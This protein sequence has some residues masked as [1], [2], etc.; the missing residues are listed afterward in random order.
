[1]AGTITH[2]KIGQEVYSKIQI[3]L[4]YNTFI[5]ACQGHDIMYFIKLKNLKNFLYIKK[6]TKKIQKTKIN[7]FIKLYEKKIIENEN[8]IYLKSFLYGYITHHI[9]DSI[10]HPYIIYKCGLTTKHSW[11]ENYIDYSFDDK[12]TYKN[13]PKLKKNSLLD[14]ITYDTLS[15]V[16]TEEIAK[17]FIPNFYNIRHFWHLYREDKFGIKKIFYKLFDKIFKTDIS[18]ISYNYKHKIDLTKKEKWHHPIDNEE[19]TSSVLDLY[20]KSIVKSVNIIKKMDKNLQKQ[21]IIEFENISSISGKDC[22]VKP[23]Y[24]Y[25]EN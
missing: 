18:Y 2:L 15:E 25:F 13:F 9:S 5:T 21:K 4:D 12:I 7:D 8:D 6:I 16:Y 23:K 3:E 19:F 14:K 24:R 1:M 17:I 22:S 20:H 10:F 11:L